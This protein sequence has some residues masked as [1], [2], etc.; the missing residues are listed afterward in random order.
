MYLIHLLLNAFFILKYPNCNTIQIEKGII[1]EYMILNKA[2]ILF[3]FLKLN[4]KHFMQISV[5]ADAGI[6]CTAGF[7]GKVLV[8]DFM[9]DLCRFTDFTYLGVI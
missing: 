1:N 7:Q 5:F 4:L 6:Q 9:N 8:S 2:E 3:S